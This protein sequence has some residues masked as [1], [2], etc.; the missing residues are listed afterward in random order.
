MKTLV[1]RPAPSQATRMAGTFERLESKVRSYCRSFPTVFAT[2]KGAVLTDVD[3]RRFLD[4]LSA[5]GSLNYGH[6]HEY[7]VRAAKEHFDQGFLIQGLDMYTAPKCRFIEI[8]EKHILK[9]RGMGNYRFQFTGPTGANAVEAAMKLA[10]L[11]TKKS[12]I[13]CFTNA[14]HGLSIGALGLTGSVSKRMAAGV[15]LSG[16]M[17]LPY[18]G[19]IPDSLAFLRKVFHDPSSG[20]EAPAAFMVETVQG[21]GGLTTASREW[22][23]GLQT[24]AREIGSLLIVDD[25]QAGCGRTGTF[26]S[27]ENLGIEPDIICLSKSISGLGLPMSILL[28]KDAID[29]WQPG[30]HEGTFRGNNLAFTTAAAA[31]ENFWT[32]DAF[33]KSV[34]KKAEYVANRLKAIDDG[35]VVGRGLIT[36]LS[37]TN[38][39][40][41]KGVSRAC[42]ERGLIAET[43]GPNG[44]VLKLL[45]SLTIEDDQLAEGMDIL[46]DAVAACR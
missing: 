21:E 34:R 29:V 3:G 26:F 2:G 17:R 33:E 11:A 9:P 10:R 28:F 8:F 16:A 15:P 39:E 5:A 7:L 36:G 37:F 4:F 22:L 6:N 1:E 14:Y 31:I 18:E 42:F 45:P 12:A 41:A 46:A 24:L 30:G 35:G 27:F 40:T 32:D 25:I 43:C 38:R 20:F 19:Y 13:A 23:V 44:E